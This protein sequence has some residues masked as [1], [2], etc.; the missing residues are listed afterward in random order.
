MV[1]LLAGV[2]IGFPPKTKSKNV[3]QGTTANFG[4]VYQTPHDRAFA[5]ISSSPV[6]ELE[7]HLSLPRYPRACYTIVDPSPSSLSSSIT[8]TFDFYVLQQKESIRWEANVNQPLHWFLLKVLILLLHTPT[9]VQVSCPPHPIPL[10]HW[11]FVWLWFCGTY[12]ICITITTPV[13]VI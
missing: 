13:M 7:S 9:Q 10:Y 5:A 3:P 1:H 6:L 4:P 11:F 8:M 12:Y 2:A